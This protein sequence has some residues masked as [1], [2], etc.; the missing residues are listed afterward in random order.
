MLNFDALSQL[1]SLKQEIHQSVPRHEGK[2]RATGG[3]YGFVNTDDNQQFFLN[4]DEMDKVLA[5]DMIAFRVEETKEGKSQAIIEKLISSAQDEFVGQYIVKGK[6][7]FISPDH[8]TFNR[9]VFV[10]PAKRNSAKDGDLVACKISQH[11]YPHGKVQADVLE[12]VGQTSDRQIESN[13]MM[14]KWDIAGEFSEHCNDEAQALLSVMDEATTTEVRNDLTALNW[15]TIDSAMS[16]DLDDALHCEKTASGWDLHVAIADPSCAIKPGSEIDKEALRRG[17][18]SYFADNMIPMLP[19]SLS[20]GA[21]S[22]LPEQVRP[23]MVCHLT[24]SEQG[25]VTNCRI[26]NALIESKAKLSYVQVAAFLEGINNDLVALIAEPIKPILS[27]LNECALA[28]NGY[29]RRNNLVLDDRIEFKATLNESGKVEQIISLERNQAHKLVEECMVAVNRSVAN[30]LAEKEHG[31]FIQH[32]GIRSERQGEARALVKEQLGVANPEKVANLEGFIEIQQLIAAGNPDADGAPF[33]LPLQAIL[34]RQLERSKYGT[35]VK[36]HVGMG[37]PAYTTFTS[38]IRK[39]NDLLVH[40]LV[41][42]YLAEAQSEESQLSPISAEILEQVGKAQNNSRMAAWQSDQWLKAEWLLRQYAE[43]KK[44]PES[45][46]RGGQIVQVNSGGFTVRLDDC[47]IEGQVDVRRNKEW[48]FDTK[49]MT[50]SKGEV[51]Y[52]LEQKVNVSIAG[53]T[54]VLREVKFTLCEA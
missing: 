48:K 30:F 32:A 5:G 46:L 2:V 22:L 14:R 34:A 42:A 43:E 7:H 50:H 54:P 33:E 16:R 27:I 45:L 35:E 29:R 23:A 18:S 15:L 38:P 51:T 41:K 25:E 9:W 10:P 37:L 36:P 17:T 39:Y 8:P 12:V 6:G 26:E 40:R 21:F 44:G 1:K 13:M 49:T 52:R 47:G 11:P 19:S 31:L 4:P 24:I 3:R 20:E 53:I 28:L